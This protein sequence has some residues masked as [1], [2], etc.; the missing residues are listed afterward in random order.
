MEDMLS[1]AWRSW[2]EGKAINIVDPSVNSNSQHEMLRCIHNGL[3]YVQENLVDRPTMATIVLML[4]S[5]SL[6]L[7]IRAEPAFYM[8]S[9]TKIFPKMHSWEYNSR[10]RG[11]SELILKSAQESENE[12]SITELYPR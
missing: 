12:A 7:P 2:K 6:S 5:H 11:S 4:N 1:F 10:E 9:R 8:N 3:L